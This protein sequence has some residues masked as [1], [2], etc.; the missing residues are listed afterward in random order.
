MGISIKKARESDSDFLAMMMLD[1]SR[2]GKKV[3]IFDLIF[4]TNDNERVAQR[5]KELLL[6]EIKSEYHYS[7]FL[8]A[9]ED[10]ADVGI[11]CGYEARIAT[12]ESLTE[13]LASIGVDAG[14]LER[15]S[16]YLLCLPNFDKQTWVLDMMRVTDQAHE[17][18]ILKELI[19]KSLLTARLK[20]YHKA[21]TIVDVGDGET[22]LVYEKLGFSYIDEKLSDEYLIDFGPSGIMRLGITL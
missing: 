12:T 9:V 17:Y 21:Q 10:D 6:S 11:L 4:E 14:Y 18:T 19:Q 1:F 5:I 15:I 8:I 16:S 2:R 7:N 3:G 13:A 20:G 22:K